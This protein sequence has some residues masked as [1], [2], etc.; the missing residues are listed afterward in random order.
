M[1]SFEGHAI[2]SAD[3]MIADAAGEVPPALRNDADWRQYQSALDKAV[4]VATGRVGHRRYPNPGR[5]RLVL[6]R[7]VEALTPD[8]EDPLATLWNPAG[9]SLG[10]VLESLGVKAGNIAITGL[11]DVFQPHLTA[12]QLSEQHRLVLPGGI[13]CFTGGH[14]RAVLTALGMRPASVEL[15]DGPALVTSTRWVLDSPRPRS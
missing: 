5:R 9:L 3:G 2:V 15:I 12:F 13:P 10:D 1:L 11:F 14:P 6:T 7:A 4:L 8:P